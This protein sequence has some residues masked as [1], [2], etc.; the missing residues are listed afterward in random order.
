LKEEGFREENILVFPFLDLRYEGQSYE[1][2]IPYKKAGTNTFTSFVTDFHQAHQKLYS[3]HHAQRQVEIVNVRLKVVGKSR[4]LRLR[5]LPYKTKNPSKAFLKKQPLYHG[6]RKYTA[7]VF[8][9]SLLEPGNQIKGPA[10]IVDCEST[11]F[12]PP[13][14]ELTVDNF[15]NLVLQKQGI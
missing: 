15:L 5:R 13:S 3:Y 1:I 8:L 7:S 6:R 11:T 2:T 14:F 10:L 12:L 9:R 4:K